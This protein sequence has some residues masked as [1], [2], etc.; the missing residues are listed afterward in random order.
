MPD[1]SDLG[2]AATGVASS[3]L[4]WCEFSLRVVAAV[5]VLSVVETCS[6]GCETKRGLNYL[7]CK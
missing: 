5:R 2:F 6:C 1:E 7:S 4:V 3:L